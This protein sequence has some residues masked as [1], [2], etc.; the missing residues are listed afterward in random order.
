MILPWEQ[1]Y[2]EQMLP[3][4]MPTPA[5]S[6]MVGPLLGESYQQTNAGFNILWLFIIGEKHIQLEYWMNLDAFWIVTRE[7][8]MAKVN[9]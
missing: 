6:L 3:L 8:S 7:L 5:F 2:K 9:F 4:K 1:S